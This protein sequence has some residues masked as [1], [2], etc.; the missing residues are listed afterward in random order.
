MYGTP[1]EAYPMGHIAEE[2]VHDESDPFAWRDADYYDA[3]PAS[4]LLD[5]EAAESP[6]EGSSADESGSGSDA[7]YPRQGRRHRHYFPQFMRLPPEIRQ[8]IWGFFCPDLAAKHR[9]FWLDARPKGFELT[10]AVIITPYSIWEQHTKPNRTIL[11]VH[12]ESRSLALKAFP[13]T[14]RT[15]RGI[16]RFNAKKDVI[17]LN[18]VERLFYRYGEVPLVCGFTENIQHLAVPLSVFSIRPRWGPLAIPPFSQFKN[19]KTFYCFLDADDHSPELLNWCASDLVTRYE[20]E[21]FERQPGLGEDAQVLHCWPDLENHR[22][23]A[24][25]EISAESLIRDRHINPMEIKRTLPDGVEIWPM[26][27]FLKYDS[28]AEWFPPGWDGEGDQDDDS[29]A[30]GGHPLGSEG[31][32]LDEYES[33]G[34]DDSEIDED[35]SDSDDDLALMH[36]DGLLEDDLVEDGQQ[37]QARFSSPDASSSRA[38]ESGGSE[39]D[40]PPP[41]RSRLKRSR[42]RVV[43]SSSGSDTEASGPRKRPRTERRRV[44]Q[45]SDD[46]EEDED[47]ERPRIR[48]AR[49]QRGV[50][51][52]DGEEPDE[53]EQDSHNRRH[54]SQMHDAEAEWSGISSS[55]EDEE[56]EGGAS[57]GRPMTLAEKLQLHR[58]EVQIPQSD[59]GDSD[60]EET[61]GY[62]YDARDYADF[63]DDEEGN[64]ISDE[65]DDRQDELA[66]DEEYEEYGDY[67]Y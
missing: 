2:S 51:S 30:Y 50:S 6:D 39:E 45:S 67:E 55:D 23:F 9:V 36:D 59:E 7:P 40:Q 58:E 3:D 46:E 4:H 65:G 27:H 54:A 60:V 29:E 35:G 48:A 8:Q 21:N 62:D 47:H 12:A 63:Q 42:D 10:N 26:V 66:M 41:T 13:D 31:E 1:Q 44:F 34:I 28:A 5:L 52:E 32:N 24:E 43:E 53:V 33:E 37:N 64:E 14:L 57:V 61:A 11:A 18:S 25:K 20:C 56:S 19:L 15:S 22:A 38:Q 49:R 16:L 17:V